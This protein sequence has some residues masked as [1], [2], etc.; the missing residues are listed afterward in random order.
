M[1]LDSPIQLL[2]IAL[3]GLLGGA[4]NAVVGSG[5]LISFPVLVAA[6][7]PPVPANGT[8][9][10]GLSFGSFSSALAYRSELRPHWRYLRFP[11]LASLIGAA[12][13]ASLVLVFPPTVFEFLVPW[14]IAMAAILV[15]IQPRVNRWVSGRPS[16]HRHPVLLPLGAGIVGIYGGYFGA[17]QG[18]MLM[19]VLGATY[20]SDM[21]IANGAK[22]LLAA[23]ANITAAVVFIVTGNVVWLAAMTLAIGAIVG[24][25]VGGRLARKIAS[26]WLR[27]IVVA[28]GFVAAIALAVHLLWN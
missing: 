15:A 20:D 21:Q 28:V 14:L 7:I 12:C 8:N 23:V 3:A 5:T 18:V 22:N 10:T 13:G 6:G 9:T 24:G 11:V 19:A 16:I 25:Y 17:G 26:V 1:L 27:R 2:V 4:V